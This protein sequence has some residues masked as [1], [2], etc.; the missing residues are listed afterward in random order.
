MAY[1]I[2]ISSV[3]VLSRRQL[4]EYPCYVY[5]HSDYEVPPVFKLPFWFKEEYQNYN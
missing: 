1:N 5:M 3:R 2:G 4:K